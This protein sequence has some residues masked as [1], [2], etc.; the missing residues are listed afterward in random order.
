[1]GM[2]LSREHGLAQMLEWARIVRG[3]ALAH[4]GREAEGIAEIRKSIEKQHAMRSLV[5]R[6]YCLTLLAE[7]LVRQG[8]WKEALSLCGEALDIAQRTEGRSYEPETH[9]IRGE[10]L[11][12]C[13]EDR[14]LPE[15]EAEFESALVTAQ[16][17]GCRLLELRAAMSYFRQRCRLRDNA[18]GRVLLAKVLSELPE[19]L[20]SPVGLRARELVER[21]ASLE[22]QNSRHDC[23]H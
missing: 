4:L 6:S 18:G 13:G 17:A 14:R 21:W 22:H 5:D 3:S 15:A 2:A 11:L 20:N 8:A 23:Y 7:A 19:G 1:M 10:T 16:Q 9:R 12:L